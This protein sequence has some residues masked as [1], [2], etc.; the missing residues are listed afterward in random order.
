MKIQRNQG[1]EPDQNHFIAVNNVYNQ[2]PRLTQ[3]GHKIRIGKMSTTWSKQT[4]QVVLQWNGVWLKAVEGNGDR[5]AWERKALN[6][7]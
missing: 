6:G 2:S 5:V 4:H 3:P 7:H 1:R